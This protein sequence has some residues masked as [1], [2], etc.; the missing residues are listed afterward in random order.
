MPSVRVEAGSRLHAG[1]YLVGAAEWG[2][3]WAGAGFYASEPRVLVEAWECNE[4]VILAPGYEDVI[5][6]VEAN[7]PKG[8]C[9]RLLE[10]PPR[11]H[12]LGATT[13]VL[14]SLYTGLH[15]AA[16]DPLGGEALVEA[17][18]Q[19]LG[20]QKGSSVGTLLFA[21]GGF[22]ADPGVPLAGI[23]PSPVRLEVPDDW[24]YIIVIPSA[25]RGLGEREEEPVLARPRP[26]SHRADYLMGRGFRLLLVGLMRRSLETV[27]EGLRH[28]QTGT[29]LYF[30][31]LQGGVFRGDI[32]ALAGEASRDGI[33]LAQ[34]SW[35]PTLYTIT[36]AEWAESDAKTLKMIADELG[37]R[38]SIVV[39]RPR[40]TGASIRLT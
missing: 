28:M 17:G 2:I 34:S 11:H 15:A 22:V 16:G 33:V 9:A 10:A 4:P 29:G 31:E 36:R 5:G 23:T 37:I 1:F 12:G 19:R 13:Q 27:I 14:L 18:L 6:V 3:H 25:E 24:R 39:S 30:S 32:A 21:Y 40:N 8:A 38:A 20:R 35:G 26:P 7:A